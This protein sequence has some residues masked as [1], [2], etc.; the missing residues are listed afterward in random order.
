MKVSAKVKS[1]VGAL[2]AI[3]GALVGSTGVSADDAATKSYEK[4]ITQVSSS[5]G[6]AG[7]DDPM[8]TVKKVIDVAVG[9]IGVIAVIMVIIGGYQYATSVGDAGKVKNAKNTIMYGLIGMVIALLAYAIVH[10]VLGQIF[11]DGSTS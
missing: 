8:T 1:K 3:G 11:G 6:D 4:Y 10:F 2:A 7:K 5:F 9:V